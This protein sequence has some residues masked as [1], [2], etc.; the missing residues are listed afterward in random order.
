MI[1]LQRTVVHLL[2]DLTH[3]VCH[4][5]ALLASAMLCGDSA[6][7]CEDFSEMTFLTFMYKELDY[8]RKCG[9]C[10]TGYYTFTLSENVY[11]DICLSPLD[12]LTEN[13]IDLET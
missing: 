10:N 7:S 9:N 5:L 11:I 8:G 2:E 1:I 6:W 13:E 12:F 3:F 4:I